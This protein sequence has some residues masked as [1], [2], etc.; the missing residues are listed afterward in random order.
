MLRAALFCNNP[1]PLSVQ[2]FPLLLPSSPYKSLSLYCFI[3]QSGIAGEPT[4]ACSEV[5]GYNDCLLLAT[6]S[7]Y[8][9]L[10]LL[11]FTLLPIPSSGIN[12]NVNSCTSCRRPWTCVRSPPGATR[13]A[14]SALKTI[15]WRR[16]IFRG[17][18]SISDGN[19]SEGCP[20]DRRVRPSMRRTLM[21]VNILTSIQIPPRSDALHIRDKYC[22]V[23]YEA[24]S[25]HDQHPKFESSKGQFRPF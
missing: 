11:P 5:T 14:F 18:F 23:S 13:R 8:C 12:I 4:D 24:W 3:T 7:D 20:T 1:L 10:N 19:K 15:G 25:I 6:I 21:P 2:P 17:S 22:P 16:K 9:S